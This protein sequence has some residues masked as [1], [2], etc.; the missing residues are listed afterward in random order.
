M[1]TAA[2]EIKES[3]MIAMMDPDGLPRAYGVAPTEGHA[4]DI[5]HSELAKYRVKKKET[6]D[7]LAVA[8]FTERMSKPC[9]VCGVWVWADEHWSLWDC[10]DTGVGVFVCEPC[11]TKETP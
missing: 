6:G 4:R 5:A 7:P 2:E 10:N 8:K 1:N 9:E 11:A 3:Y